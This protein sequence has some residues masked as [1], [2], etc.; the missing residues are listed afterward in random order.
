MTNRFNR[1]IP[2]PIPDNTRRI[3]YWIGIIFH[4]FSLFVPALLLVMR[5]EPFLE[6]VGW[7]ALISLITLPPILTVLW[8][9]QRNKREVYQR[10]SR[11][12][13]YVTTWLS[14][15]VALFALMILDAPQRIIATLIAGI[16]WLPLQLSVNYFYTKIS[17]HAGVSMGTVVGLYMMGEVDTI[18]KQLVGVFIILSVGWARFMTKNHTPEQIILGWIVAA[19]AIVLTFSL[20]L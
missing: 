1:D 20:A 14:F 7:I 9:V 13:I 17:A 11:E 16:V 4:P 15:W 18:V 12:P 3:A 5:N 10:T 19:T 6:A 8:W 2:D